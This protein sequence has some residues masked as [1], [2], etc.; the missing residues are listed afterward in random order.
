MKHLFP[1]IA[2]L[3]TIGTTFAQDAPPPLEATI[4]FTPPVIQDDGD[5]YNY[6]Y[7]DDDMQCF[8]FKSEN[9]EDSLVYAEEVIL[10]YGWNN[11][12]A[13]LVIQNQQYNENTDVSEEVN[14]EGEVVGLFISAPI[15]FT[16]I[17][18]TF[19]IEND[20]FIFTPDDP[21][22]HAP[23]EFKIQFDPE[24]NR[25]ESLIL[26]EKESILTRGECMEATIS[27]GG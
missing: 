24:T 1:L 8:R 14:A 2:L 19:L 13:R 27:I 21:E 5:W 6:E 22:V 3:L 15:E 7:Q 4:E 20:R 9:R 11:D 12:L 18:G 23:A 16:Y 17:E 25:I 26:S 10:E